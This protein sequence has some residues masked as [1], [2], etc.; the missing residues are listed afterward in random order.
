RSC[1]TSSFSTA[2]SMTTSASTAAPSR[3]VVDSSRA[4]AASDSACESRP[5]ATLR[6]MTPVRFAR[7]FS[8][9]S[10]AMSCRRTRY[11]ARAHAI[12]I[13]APIAPAPTTRILPSVGVSAALFSTSVSSSSGRAAPA[14]SSPSKIDATPTRGVHYGQTGWLPPAVGATRG[15]SGETAQ[16]GQHVLGE[17]AEVTALVVPGS[18]EHQVVEAGVEVGLDL[19]HRL[20]GAG[21][22]DPPLG[23]LLD[24]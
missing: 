8:R 19:L 7:A 15:A 5:L 6:S 13:C 17:L 14:A 20:V 22:H 3:S 10:S 1:L 18:V 4:N 23:H 21:G 12:A 16:P 9:L 11:P 2:A 24:G